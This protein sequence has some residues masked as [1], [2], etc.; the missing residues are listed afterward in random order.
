[1]SLNRNEQLVLDYLM[2]HPEERHHWEG[3]VRKTFFE[4][5]DPHSAA[6]LLDGELWRYYE[7]RSTVTAPFRAEALREGLRRISMKNLAEY[8]I[9]LWTP[10][11][12]TK[13]AVGREPRDVFP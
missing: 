6:S 8:L 2:S 12:I 5:Q 4:S 7:E 1:M 11:R 3:K 10:P 9:R 13:K